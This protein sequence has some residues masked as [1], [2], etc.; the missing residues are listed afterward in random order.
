[1]VEDL[2]GKILGSFLNEKTP[3]V[4]ACKRYID[5]QEDKHGGLLKCL[6]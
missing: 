3:R 1:M 5:L 2:Q 4:K 6:E